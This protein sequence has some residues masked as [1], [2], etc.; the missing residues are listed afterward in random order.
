MALI[1]AVQI[2]PAVPTIVVNVAADGLNVRTVPNGP[3]LVALVN[4]T[5]VIPLQRQGD[6]LLIAAGCD[7]T[8]QRGSR[9]RPKHRRGNGSVRY[10]DAGNTVFIAGVGLLALALA[11]AAN[12]YLHI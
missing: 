4:G 6:W 8:K 3:P 7:L 12:F 5:P 1:R 11:I 2:H 9:S 10:F